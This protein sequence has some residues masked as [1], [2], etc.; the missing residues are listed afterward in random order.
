MNKTK[1]NV[2]MTSA[3]PEQRTT[4]INTSVS[5]QGEAKNAQLE[6]EKRIT[7]ILDVASKLENPTN[8]P[9]LSR[10]TLKT[11]GTKA[12]FDVLCIFLRAIDGHTERADFSSSS[13]NT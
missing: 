10:E 8:T 2:H 9:A 13:T 7:R 12:F 5:K 1:N 3:H 11:G 6:Q 4:I